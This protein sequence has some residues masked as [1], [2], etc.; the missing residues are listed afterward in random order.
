MAKQLMK[1]VSLC[2]LALFMSDIGIYAQSDTPEVTLD[3]TDKT[4]WNI[5]TSGTNTALG[6]YTNGSYTIK[7]Y[8]TTNYKMNNGYLILG[9]KDS[10]LELPPFDFDVEKIEVIGHSGASASVK[11]NIYAEGVAVSEET[12]GADGVTNVYE[13]TESA[14]TSGTLYKL[15]VTSSHNTQIDAIKIYKKSSGGETVTVAKP[16]FSV[17]GGKCYEPFELSL[18]CSTEGASIYYTLDGTDPS[19]ASTVYTSA[20]TISETTTVKAVAVSGEQTSEIASDLKDKI[21]Q[22]DWIKK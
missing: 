8:A 6:E 10:Y 4:A 17:N 9:K 19:S 16:A 18:S 12:T 3:F 22:P 15:M 11:Q 5:P 7:L 14:Q 2:M 1:Y 21:Q 20:I 13:I